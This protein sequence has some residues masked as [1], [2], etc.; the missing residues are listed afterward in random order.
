[1]PQIDRFLR[2]RPSIPSHR[3]LGLGYSLVRETWDIGADPKATRPILEVIASRRSAADAAD[4]GRS[5]AQAFARH[6]FH[7]PSGAWWAAGQG[8]FH[9]FAV[10]PRYRARTALV[11]GLG[12]AGLAALRLAHVARRPRALGY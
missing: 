8:L 5:S 1:M 3:P 12:V 9:R 4:L 6:G 10:R 11:F 7:K 2:H